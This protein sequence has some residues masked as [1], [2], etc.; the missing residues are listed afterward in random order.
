MGIP[1]VGKMEFNEEVFEADFIGRRTVK[2]VR[3]DCFQPSFDDCTTIRC[4]PL[5]GAEAFF[6]DAGDL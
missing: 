3:C 2:S 1:P 4:E 6:I 5:N